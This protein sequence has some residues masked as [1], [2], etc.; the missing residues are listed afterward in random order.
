M[1]NMGQIMAFIK[2]EKLPNEKRFD[3]FNANRIRHQ[4]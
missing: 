1:I 2:I 3:L 4:L